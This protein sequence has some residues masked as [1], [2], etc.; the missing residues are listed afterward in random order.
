MRAS[1]SLFVLGAFASACLSASNG[2]ALA[3][4][5]GPLV[6]QGTLVVPYSENPMMIVCPAALVC[7][8][9]LQPGEHILGKTNAYDTVSFQFDVE[10]G[11]TTPNPYIDLKPTHDELVTNIVVHTD[12]RRYNLLILTR[13]SGFH[14]TI[15]FTYPGDPTSSGY[16]VTA[17]RVALH[18]LVPVADPTKFDFD[19]SP[20]Q[21][22]RG[23]DFAPTQ[24][25]SDNVH[26]YV[27]LPD[28]FNNLPVLVI[29]PPDSRD[30]NCGYARDH[31]QQV[32]QRFVNGTFMVDG[33]PQRLALL[34]GSGADQCVIISK[35]ASKR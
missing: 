18:P 1:F 30:L 12:R 20:W 4:P 19:Y 34:D 14:R 16:I 25:F 32:N 21:S 3:G 9:N 28:H 35:G 2:V 7:D 15:A 27:K 11:D 24:V 10:R 31:Q 22:G 6:R 5:V 33:S 17:K 13:N 8:I 23:L 29:L 26:V